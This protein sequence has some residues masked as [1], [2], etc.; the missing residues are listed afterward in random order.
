MP[1][2]ELLDYTQPDENIQEL[3]RQKNIEVGAKVLS[4]AGFDGTYKQITDSSLSKVKNRGEKL[5]GSGSE[6]RAAAYLTR[7]Y[8]IVERH[9]T[10]A[11]QRFLNDTL[12]NLVINPDNIP[13]SYWHAQEQIL[14]DNGQ[15]R[16]LSDHDKKFLASKII[17]QQRESLR[18]WGEYLGHKDCPYPTWFKVYAING[19]SK[20]GAFD[21]DKRV[22]RKR[23]ETTVA[24]YPRL[25]AA[26]LGKTYDAIADF[27]NLGQKDFADQPHNSKESEARDIQLEAL[28]RSGNFNKLYSRLLLEKKVVLKTPERSE[29]VHGTWREYLPS[30]EERL[31]KAA[32]GT[33]W[34]IAS[35]AVAKSYLEDSYYDNDWDNQA[36]FILFHLQ[37]PETGALAENACASIRLDNAGQVAEVSG[38]N[39]GQALEDSLVPTVQEKVLSLP[40]GEE[41]QQAFEDKQHLIAMDRKMQAGEYDF[42]EDDIRFIFESDR[43]ISTL[44]TY[45]DT[46]PRVSELRVYIL[47]DKNFKERHPE[48]LNI[49]CD[50]LDLRKTEITSLP[51]GLNVDGW[52]FL[53]GSAITSLPD[54]LNVGG[55]L[56]IDN[57]PINS[58]PRG[59]NIKGRL[60]A[61][62]TRI[63]S[64]PEDLNVGGNIFLEDSDI[65]SLPEGLN[66][67]GH[68]HLCRSHITSLPN[69]LSVEGNLDI[70]GCNVT[71][72]PTDLKV[73][74]N[75][76]L[77][78]S[79]K[80]SVPDSV[81]VGGKVYYSY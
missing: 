75:L 76:I 59:L 64:L 44:D 67:H 8:D 5:T 40:S 68:L 43:E 2:N 66:V 35:P 14:R 1:N 4:A 23:D 13:D 57:T 81:Y 46:D 51:E 65:I 19:I 36:K 6:R 28:V 11:E 58:L 29:D 18:P 79:T 45:N 70:R 26:T 15:A 22:F 16:E 74:G 80:P 77:P 33:P 12:A 20:M 7:L 30:D 62:N 61:N 48:G 38:L 37:D 73:G 21:K 31:A 17:N 25:D 53:D 27:Y 3:H 50:L 34:C 78:M 41:Y 54:N 42:S 55:S 60:Y 52:M 32:D 10:V 56:S 49:S 72:V 24:P 69:G 39:D 9:G 47:S 71:S 63:T